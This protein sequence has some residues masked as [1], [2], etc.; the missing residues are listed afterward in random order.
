MTSDTASLFTHFSSLPYQVFSLFPIEIYYLVN[1][2]WVRS[3]LRTQVGYISTRWSALKR[4][5]Q[6]LCSYKTGFKRERSLSTKWGKILSILKRKTSVAR[7]LL[8]RYYW[9]PILRILY[10]EFTNGTHEIDFSC[11]VSHSFLLLLMP[12]YYSTDVSL[13][14]WIIHIV[15]EFFQRFRRSELSQDFGFWLI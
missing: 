12:L 11:G 7:Y 15:S 14:Y 9:F 10:L 3:I 4:K 1:E 6:S 8:D 2:Y 13:F 5:K